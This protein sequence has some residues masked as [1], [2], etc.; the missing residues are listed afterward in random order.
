[1][2]LMQQCVHLNLH[3]MIKLNYPLVLLAELGEYLNGLVDD[4]ES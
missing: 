2:L 1:M 3:L 4:P